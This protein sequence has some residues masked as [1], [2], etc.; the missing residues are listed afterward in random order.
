MVIV[1]DMM[2]PEA[3]ES[4]IA[5][6]CVSSLDNILSSVRVGGRERTKKEFEALCKLSGF[7][8]FQ[9]VCCAFSLLGVMEFIK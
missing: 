1:I 2:M 9:F 4:T 8:T 7:S 6:K 5:A 3:P